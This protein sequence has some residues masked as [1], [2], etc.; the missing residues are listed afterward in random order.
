MEMGL[1]LYCHRMTEG[2]LI[3]GPECRSCR[4]DQLVS[5]HREAV[6]EYLSH[7]GYLTRGKAVVVGDLVVHEVK[8]GL[9]EPPVTQVAG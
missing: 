8:G 2:T 9:I 4:A 3:A 1:A 6:V 7:P 5:R